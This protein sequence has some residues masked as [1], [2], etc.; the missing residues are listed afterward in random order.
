MIPIQLAIVDPETRREMPRGETGEVWLS[1]PSVT[2]GYWGRPELT[3]EAFSARIAEEDGADS[4]DT[5]GCVSTGLRPGQRYPLPPPPC[6]PRHPLVFFLLLGV[7]NS[8]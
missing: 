4:D 6:F 1:S 5:T 3:E 2:A 8:N 7:L